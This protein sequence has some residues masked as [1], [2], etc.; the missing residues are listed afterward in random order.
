M[1]KKTK[2]LVSVISFIMLVM[3]FSIAVFGSEIIKGNISDN[4]F[5]TGV[6]DVD[7]MPDDNGKTGNAGDP[8]IANEGFLLVPGMEYKQKFHIVN[9]S[10]ENAYCKIKME[11]AEGDLL[12][13]LYI[14]ISED[15]A[16]Q[17]LIYS[18]MAE[19]LINEGTS[20]FI[21]SKEVKDKEMYIFFCLPQTATNAVKDK[22]VSFKLS[23]IAVQEKNNS[24]KD[25]GE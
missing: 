25:F 1:N 21:L 6:I 23:A 7:I 16:G 20:A 4:T 2:S 18:G 14:K 24:E 12:N 15:T 5:K 9:K 3:I 11:E 8:I 17:N 13:T 22:I 10:T 19:G